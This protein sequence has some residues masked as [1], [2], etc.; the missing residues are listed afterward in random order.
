[1]S[2]FRRTTV[3]VTAALLC[4]GI[5]AGAE[6]T[7]APKWGAHMEIEG[8]AG[9]DRSS[10]MGD[11]FVPLWQND[12]SLLA[13]NF[14]ARFHGDDGGEG[15]FGLVLRR[16]LA[17]GW[18][19][20]I[21]GFYDVRRTGWDNTFHQATIGAELL[22]R[23]FDLR[24]NGYLPV[25]TTSQAVNSLT[26]T[27]I[28]GSRVVLRG[29]EELAMRGLDAEI[30]WRVPV[31]E[32]DSGAALRIFG[33]G[34]HF[35]NGSPDVRDITGAR[36]RLELS[37]DA[38]SFLPEGA[39]FTLGGEVQNDSVRGTQAAGYARLRIPL[40]GGRSSL[41][42][43]E[44]RMT[45]FVMR[46]ID[47][48][49]QAGAFG[50][51][52]IAATQ[53]G[54]SLYVFDPG[55]T[56]DLAAAIA[57]A[58]ANST[59][60]LAGMFDVTVDNALDTVRLQTGQTVMG[61][62]NITVA[63][64]S[65]LTATLTSPTRGG[66]NASMNAS[67]NL[68]AVAM[69]DNGTLQGVTINAVQTGGLFSVYGVEANGVSGATITDSVISA[70]NSTSGAAGVRLIGGSTNITVTGNTV[71]AVNTNASGTALALQLSNSTAKVAD[72]RFSALT[73]GTD[74][75]V[76][77][78]NSTMLPGSSGNV[79][80]EGTCQPVGANSGTLGFTD[81]TTCP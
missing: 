7:G 8:R 55:T 22:G 23:D 41:T 60:I 11:F 72:N 49:T 59:V 48:V 46:D 62:G 54:Q 63:G 16:M 52:E 31:F 9:T 64:A 20:G 66:I 37:F 25:G 29:G 18:N 12:D 53:D 79:I 47:V 44:Q 77:R 35:E 3:V 67:S 42:A 27:A 76:Y 13:A 39:R 10:G 70:T 33:S 51:E 45:D 58:G 56:S 80:V 17:N 30:G 6:E 5:P 28:S 21:Y 4:G 24:F 74:Y 43:Q 78:D 38:I 36:G 50:P 69:S 40:G 14:R 73:D 32:P 15:N 81:G 19:A 65:G 1:M 68:S 75:A 71:S 57:S 34:Y 26:S 2:I 61:S